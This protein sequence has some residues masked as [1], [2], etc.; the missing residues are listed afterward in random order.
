MT[1]LPVG[2]NQHARAQLTND[3][4]DLDPIAKGVLDP[5]VGNI[6]R[7]PPTDFQDA[8]CLIGLTRPVVN[9]AAGAHL[10]LREIEDGSAVSALR[11][12][13]QRA[14]AGLL[15]VVAMGGNGQ[16]VACCALPGYD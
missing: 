8:R 15:D 1:R 3:A 7:S 6:E 4:R 12:L 16:D 10:A 9:A 13:E 11:H 14:A 2:K 5:A